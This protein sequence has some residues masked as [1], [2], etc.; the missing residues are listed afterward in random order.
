MNFID[1]QNSWQLVSAWPKFYILDL[2]G[3]VLVFP[4]ID[5]Q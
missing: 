1:Q 2:I 4:F 3:Q 5:L